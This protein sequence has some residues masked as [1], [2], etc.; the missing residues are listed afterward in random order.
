MRASKKLARLSTASGI[1][2]RL[3]SLEKQVL[4]LRKQR[5][6]TTSVENA[7]ILSLKKQVLQL[8]EQRQ[9]RD[10]RIKTLKSQL[11]DDAAQREQ[12]EQ[13]RMVKHLE[14]DLSCYL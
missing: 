4:Q 5:L 9:E 3:L 14:E 7:R 1:K 13:A 2:A 10:T 8:R 12:N 6:S 11:V